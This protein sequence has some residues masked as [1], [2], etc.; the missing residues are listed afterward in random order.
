MPNEPATLLVV[1]DNPA[2]LYSTAHI[3][4]RAG[5]RVL[6]A[7]TGSR[8]VELAQGM[9][10]CVILDV[11]L[12]DF[13]GFE[14]CRRIRG[15]EKLTRVPVI[16]LSATFVNDVDKV[17]GLEVGADGYLTHPVEPPV[18]VATVKAFLRVRDAELEREQLLASERAARAEA[19]RANRIKDDFLAT[20]SHELRTPL[21]SMIGWAQLLKTGRLSA[22]DAAEGLDAIERNA[23]AQSQMIADLLDVSRITSGKL[24]LDVQ[25]VDLSTVIE[26]VVSAA[27]PAAEAKD[28]RIT[29]TLN[30]L[31]GPVAGDPARLQQVIWNLVNNAVKFTPKGGNVAVTLAR[32][33][34]HVEVVVADNGNGIDAELL[35][36]IFERFHQGDS[37]A[38]RSHG[39]L[40]LG[41][42]I[43]RQ[44]IE[45][46]GG[47]IRAESAGPDAGSK[48][49]ITLQVSAA[50]PVRSSTQTSRAAQAAR[51]SG[52]M[53]R[54][55]GIR[56]LLVDDDSDARMILSRILSQSGATTKECANVKDGLAAV[57]SFNPE[58]LVSDLG[59]PE[60]DGFD[61]I[62]E[63]RSR[64]HSVQALPAVALTA[65]ARPEDRHRALLAGFQVHI[66]KPV[67]PR[68]LTTAI[69]ALL[70]RM[71]L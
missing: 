32:V 63:V 52:E 55:N 60:Q 35:P 7:E 51:Q 1:D 3:L 20:L 11:N 21:Q 67:E 37:S 42:A 50:Q 14:V 58:V 18:L 13:S 4:R 30:P 25:Q 46:H 71:S 47:S 43:A 10:D 29:K 70:G 40:G 33:D 17:H 19:E 56:I 38:N 53:S 62:R 22:V 66:A 26:A 27:L 23:F 54:L 48:F 8:A 69:A 15:L 41:L 34:S 24:R 2:T 61:F 39:G 49:T 45:L 36:K 28:I 6:E 57:E 31:A 44:L 16:H 65:F 59:M 68:E 9:V 64:G 5:Y 12:P